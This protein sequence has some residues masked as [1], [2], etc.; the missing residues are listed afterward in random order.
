MGELFLKICGAAVLSALLIALLKRIDAESAMMLKLTAGAFVATL[1]V[2]AIA[3]LADKLYSLAEMSE[4]M[5]EHLSF[6][7]RVLAVAIITHICANICR[8]S[9]ENTLAGYVEMGGKVE[10]L[11]LSF[12]YILDI[13]E[14]SMGMI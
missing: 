12:P 7:L 3:P 5:G 11:I 6:L 8:D 9:G 2:F 13:I 10:M 1:C 4:G 14:T